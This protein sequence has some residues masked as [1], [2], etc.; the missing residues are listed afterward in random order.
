MFRLDFQSCK[1]SLF[2]LFRIQTTQIRAQRFKS[3]SS[4]DVDNIANENWIKSNLNNNYILLEQFNGIE[5]K[6]H[7]YLCDEYSDFGIHVQET[8]QS[9]SFS[10]FCMCDSIH[11]KGSNND[12]ISL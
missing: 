12:K 5:S 11:W 9:H 7:T 6:S 3:L 2:Q 8:H 10:I 4:I 1:K